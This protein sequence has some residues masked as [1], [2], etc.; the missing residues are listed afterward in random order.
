MSV[1]RQHLNLRTT[2][3]GLEWASSH[4]RRPRGEG[5]RGRSQPLC[6]DHPDGPG[7][8]PLFGTDPQGRAGRELLQHLA[9][10][11]PG[12][13]CLPLSRFTSSYKHFPHI[14]NTNTIYWLSHTSFSKSIIYL[15]RC[16]IWGAFKM[17]MSSSLSLGYVY[18][19]A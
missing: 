17:T 4:L 7:W 10:C 11:L 5:R 8:G 3:K 18:I 2:W 15:S 1:R 12:S 19:S 14:R 9:G 16:W 13:S 6:R